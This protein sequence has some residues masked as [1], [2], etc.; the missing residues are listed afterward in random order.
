MSTEESDDDILTVK[1]ADH[2]I[3]ANDALGGGDDDDG[4]ELVSLEPKIKVVTKAALAK[5]VMKKKILSNQ[6]RRVQL[7]I[8][9]TNNLST[10]TFFS[11]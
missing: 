10:C 9:G 2:D 11:L 6:V 4:D 5:K 7:T 8:D 1:R 3:A